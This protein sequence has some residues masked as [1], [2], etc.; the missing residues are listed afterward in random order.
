MFQSCEGEAH[1][2][3]ANRREDTRVAHRRVAPTLSPRR[4][5]PCRLAP[6]EP[7]TQERH[8]GIAD[9]LD[10]G[11]AVAHADR[12]RVKHQRQQAHQRHGN[13]SLQQGCHEREDDAAPQSPFVRHHV[14]GE[15]RLA[16]TGA[17]GMQ[18]AVDE[19]EAPEPPEAGGIG[20]AGPDGNG[21]RSFEEALL[22][23]DP[24]HEAGGAAAA[25]RDADAERVPGLGQ[26]GF[27]R[28]HADEDQRQRHAGH[29]G[30][31]PA[32]GQAIIT[33]LASLM[34]KST[35]GDM[36]AKKA[37][38]NF[39]LSPESSGRGLMT[40]DEQ[41]DGADARLTGALSSN[42]KDTK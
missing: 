18:H 16:V 24:A 15:N 29:R 31:S 35:P 32:Q 38:D 6:D 21:E 14:R 19:A 23:Q 28:Q 30:G 8:S 20:P 13:G 17:G 5:E 7:A 11:G 37:S 27:G 25:F 33:L 10:H 39:W 40:L 34:P 41:P 1:G 2:A 4:Y 9:L 22:G 12:G 42:S 3:G 26:G 36:L